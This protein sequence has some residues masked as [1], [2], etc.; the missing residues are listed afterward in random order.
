M[1]IPQNHAHLESL[2]NGLTLILEPNSLH[3]VVS[4]Q[5]W[6]ETGSVN[7]GAWVGAGLSHLLEH[8]VFKG[9]ALGDGASLAAMVQQAGGHWNAYTSFDRTV[10]HIDGPA[11]STQRFLEILSSMVFHPTLPEADFEREKDVIRREIDMGLDDPGQVLSHLFFSAAFRSDARRHP[12][13]GHREHFDRLTHADLLAY[14]RSRY[15]PSRAIVVVSGDIDVHEI[16]REVVRLLGDLPMGELVEPLLPTDIAG[17]G[18]CLKQQ[19]FAVSTTRSII[20]WKTPPMRDREFAAY[21]VAAAVLGRGQSSLLYRELRE[22]QELAI[23]IGAWAWCLGWG[24]GI[25]AI[26]SEAEP[27]RVTVLH[28]QVQRLLQDV[29]ALDLS[30]QLQRVKRQL[31]VTQLRGLTTASGRA[32]DLAS[33]WHVARDL[34]FTRHYVEAIQR[35][36]EDQV[37]QVIAEL[38]P[39]RAIRAELRPQQ[40]DAVLSVVS[41]RASSPSDRVCE[42]QLPNGLRVVFCLIPTCRCVP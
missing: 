31:M 25:I 39:S 9:A 3:P 35:V 24:D 8:M 42:W 27:A 36:T 14:H 28:E 11:K 32:N 7:E 34:N 12:V 16:Q 5:I 22:K 41:E 26:S 2:S 21:S 17:M 40:A 29:L 20:G 19:N 23:E 15:T 33:N 30:W 18:A 13:I 4:V 10:Y 1:E 38:V 37:K 6:V